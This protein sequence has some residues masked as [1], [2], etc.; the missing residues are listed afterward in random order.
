MTKSLE[1]IELDDDELDNRLAQSSQELFNLR[2][3][4]A[5]GRLDNSARIREVKRDVARI[6][7]EMRARE[8]KGISWVEGA[9]LQEPGRV[10]L[11]PPSPPHEG[12][13]SQ[14][15]SEAG[16]AAPEAPAA[17]AAG[18]SETEIAPTEGSRV[19]N[20]V[21]N[22]NGDADSASESGAGIVGG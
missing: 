17:A 13:E 11:A 15:P 1:L 7:T 2:F 19:D 8:L 22:E 5:T 9:T 4:L 20:E 3:Q 6:L 21:A 16:E 18:V 12:A 10:R 14:P